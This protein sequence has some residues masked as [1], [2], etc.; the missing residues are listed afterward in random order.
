MLKERVNYRYTADITENKTE[1]GLSPYS[2][3]S[4]LIPNERQKLSIG[5]FFL[6]SLLLFPK[7][8]MNTNIFLLLN[9]QAGPP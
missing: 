7:P 1:Q 4:P 5:S 3:L 6:H 2:N 9:H 8:E